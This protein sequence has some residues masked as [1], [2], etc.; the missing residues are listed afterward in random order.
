MAKDFTNTSLTTLVNQVLPT[1]S[2]KLVYNAEKKMFL[3]E[4]YTSAKGNTYFQGIQISDRV[5]VLYNV[6]VGGYGCKPT[7]LNGVTVYCFD[8]NEKKII[9][10]WCPPASSYA[11]YSD[12]YAKLVASKLLYDYLKSQMK[13]KG[14]QIGDQELSDF[15]IA[16]IDAATSNS[17]DLVA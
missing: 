11:F 2:G 7:F 15:A 3:T 6:G 17:K 13:I 16:Q 1:T 8:G 10:K 4:G 12:Y 5:A 9:G 14:I